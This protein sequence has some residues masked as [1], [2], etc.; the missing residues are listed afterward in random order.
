[1]EKVLKNKG[2]VSLVICL[3]LLVFAQWQPVAADEGMPI[4]VTVDGV[5]IAFDEQPI[6]ENDRVLV[7]MRFIFE[8][9]GAEVTWDDALQ[10]ATAKKGT[11]TIEITIDNDIMLKNGEEVVLDVPARMV[12]DRTLVPVRA[13]SEG[14]GADVDWIDEKQQV[15]IVS[16]TAGQTAPAPPPA[17]PTATKTPDAEKPTEEQTYEAITLSPADMQTLKNSYD[18][19]IRYNFEQTALPQS[20]LK[21]NTEIVKEI[22][23]KSE[24]AVTFVKDVWNWVVM[25]RIMQIQ[26]LSKEVYNFGNGTGDILDKYMNIVEDAGL[27]AS[28]YFDVSFET[29]SDKS[30]MMLISFKETDTLM[31]CK[32][33]GVVVRPSKSVRYFTAETDLFDKD[34]LYFCEVTMNARGTIGLI[35]FEKDE[36]ITAAEITLEKHLAI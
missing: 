2:C 25:Q 4:T 13:V 34:N 22:T 23:A 3:L 36:F 26:L 20:V 6:F 21:D 14:M 9:L 5:Q 29:L 28:N 16:N 1:M 35:G 12:G 24:N 17:E 30:T 11:D 27:E 8:A 33:I 7:P 32:F 15:V 18:N 10:K 31:A 19:L